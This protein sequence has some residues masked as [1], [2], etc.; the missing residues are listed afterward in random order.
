MKYAKMLGLLAVVATGLMALPGSASATGLTGS[1]DTPL[2][3][4]TVLH[5]E[6]EGPVG[7]NGSLV[8][9]CE[10]STIEGEV[11][12]A[13]SGSTTASATIY[14]LFFGNCGTRT[15][16]VIEEGT[17]E[18]HTE[19]SSPNNNGTV[20]SSGT[21]ITVL[22]HLVFSV[23]VHCIYFTSDTDIG[24]LTGGTTATLHIDDAPLQRI[25]TDF[26]CGSTSELRGSYSFDSPDTLKV[27]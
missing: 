21:I 7:I 4:G 16:S 25:S 1:G 11:T 20:T 10:E 13:G 23:T 8:V 27:H 18:F 3:V 26:G 15:V 2:G 24:R 17:L 14:E 9:E 6:S 12:N 5:A 19:I 22:A